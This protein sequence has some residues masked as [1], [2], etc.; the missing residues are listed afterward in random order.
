MCFQ[1]KAPEQIKKKKSGGKTKGIEYLHVDNQE[2]DS[3]TEPKGFVH[4]Y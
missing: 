4:L 1:V 3:R 2:G